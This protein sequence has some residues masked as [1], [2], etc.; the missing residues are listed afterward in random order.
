MWVTLEFLLEWVASGSLYLLHT[1]ALLPCTCS[2]V[3]HSGFSRWVTFQS[4]L[5]TPRP[6]VQRVRMSPNSS[7]FFPHLSGTSTV[8][9]HFLGPPQLSQQGT[10][11]FSLSPNLTWEALPN[12][13]PHLSRFDWT[14]R[15]LDNN[16]SLS[17]ILLLLCLVLLL[18]LC[19]FL[20]LFLVLLLLLL[21]LLLFLLLFFSSQCLKDASSFFLSLSPLLFIVP[22]FRPKLLLLS[23]SSSLPF[24]LVFPPC[25]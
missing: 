22:T 25:C 17:R 16:V 19:L 4:G 21:V 18:L 3:G 9:F 5:E 12:L 10:E 24:L 14:G 23:P 1:I 15:N 11:G 13:T 8:G 20:L 2:R 6:L 7:L